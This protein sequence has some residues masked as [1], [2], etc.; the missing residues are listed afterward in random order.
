MSFK[1][2]YTGDVPT[3]F[4]SIKTPAGHTWVP[5]HGDTI[6]SPI[7]LAHPLLSLVLPD[8]V[9]ET[10]VVE[11]DPASPEVTESPVAA[12]ESKEN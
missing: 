10:P 1:Y 3:V 12:D 8:D 6:L 11:P 4:V 9:P 5:N 2:V 7:A